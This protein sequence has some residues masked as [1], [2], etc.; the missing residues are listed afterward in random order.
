MRGKV[1]LLCGLLLLSMQAA[2]ARRPEPAEMP[3][4][5]KGSEPHKP[6]AAHY[7]LR[8]LVQSGKMTESEAQKTEEYMIF[9]DARRT[10]DLKEVQGMSKIARRAY[11][12]M[13]R[14]QRGNPLKEYAD[15]CRLSYERA[16]ELMD[17]MHMSDKGSKYYAKL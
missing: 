13:K 11:M 17:A 8:E 9:R 15:Y 7:Y 6:A 2:D 16:E 3:D 10:Q 5:L 12:K 14:E 1:I 4:A